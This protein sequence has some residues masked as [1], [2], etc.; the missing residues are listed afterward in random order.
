MAI[1]IDEPRW[2]AHGR[3]WAHLVSDASLAELWT[4]AAE[5]GLP[6]RSFDLDHHDV[7]AER[8]D[9]LV[10]AGA[11]PVGRAELVRRLRASGLRVVAAERP[12]RRRLLARWGTTVPDAEWIGHELLGRWAAP[13][14]AYHGLGHLSAVLE[15]LSILADGGE[16]VTRAVVV[17]AW[18]HD[19]V[20]DGRTPADEIASA[21][22]ATQLLEDVLAPDEV[23]EV[24]RLV[25][26]TID[27]R[28][29][30]D[31]RGGHA[32][33]DADLGVLGGS[34]QDYRRY[35]EEVRQE[36][37]AV[38]DADFR[39][40]RAAILRR[41]LDRPTIYRTATARRRWQEPARHNLATEL[42]ALTAT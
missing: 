7:P 20:H 5:Q 26:L 22:L 13:G 27:H 40:G 18:F 31:D 39:A 33:C 36:Y 41:I 30:P 2:P 4:F 17:A 28:T 19:A 3:L 37:A 29:E 6:A 15:H 11:Q 42:A 25:R 24:A 38:P 8:W 32:L 10:A 35:T 9:D 23:T 1:L 12:A 34:P 16:E 14:R 21:D